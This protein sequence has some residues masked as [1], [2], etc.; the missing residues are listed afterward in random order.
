MSV[1]QSREMRGS[2]ERSYSVST[3]VGRGRGPS[4]TGQNR[5]LQRGPSR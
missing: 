5:K 4:E 1:S 2:R 3:F